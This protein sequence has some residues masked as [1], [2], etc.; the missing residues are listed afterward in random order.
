[1]TVKTFEDLAKIDTDELFELTVPADI[2][3]RIEEHPSPGAFKNLSKLKRLGLC[4]PDAVMSLLAVAPVDPVNLMAKLY[5]VD[6]TGWVFDRMY[7]MMVRVLAQDDAKHP[8]ATLNVD[9]LGSCVV[10]NALN[11]ANQLT[12]FRAV[13]ATD[14]RDTLL[15]EIQTLVEDAVFAAKRE[16]TNRKNKKG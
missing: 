7:F 12:V 10:A 15:Q 13:D 16:A 4:T 2:K 5:R 3:F 9:L 6:P 8:I 14:D 1:M 11:E